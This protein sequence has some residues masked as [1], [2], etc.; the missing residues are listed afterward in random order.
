MKI[1]FVVNDVITEQTGYT[2]TRLAMAAIN[3]GHEAWVIGAGDFAYDADEAV[4]ARAT[5]A[6]KSQY[7]SSDTYMADLKGRRARLERISVDE[8][9][10][11]LLRNDPS[12]DLAHR[13][14]AQASGI[15][16]GRVAMRRGLIV[17]NDPNGL[18]KASNKMYFQL[19]PEE[20]RP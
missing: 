19:Y 2:T 11:L 8:L 9:D 10:V 16:F 7:K 13:A 4:R 3:R 14:W 5:M 20:V 17:L 1:G 18:S 6:P 12:S 15:I